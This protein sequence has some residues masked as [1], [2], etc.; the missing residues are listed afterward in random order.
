MMT[1]R[2]ADYLR[3]VCPIFW[4]LVYFLIKE[5]KMEQ[6]TYEFLYTL[7]VI[8]DVLFKFMIIVLIKIYIRR[9]I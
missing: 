8:A 4:C 7:E 9:E 1:S 6:M 5:N 2:R 3:I